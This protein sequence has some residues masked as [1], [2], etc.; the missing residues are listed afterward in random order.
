MISEKSGTSHFFFY[1]ILIVLKHKVVLIGDSLVG[2]TSLMHR[3]T[4]DTFRQSCKTTIGTGFGTWST[5]VDDDDLSLQIWDTAGQEKYKS[6]GG[7]FY[8][9]AEAAIVVY[10]K[11]DTTSAKNVEQWVEQFRSIMGTEPFIAVAANKADITNSN[12]ESL[13]C[14]IENWAKENGLFYIETS[15]KTG[16]NVRELFQKVA[17]AIYE[18]FAEPSKIILPPVSLVQVHPETQRMCC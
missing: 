9:N 17:R 13:S 10:S 15:A 11:D 12:D 14:E 1:L 16:K 2:K 18:K 4:R 5:L 3:L 6:L 8:Q 7:I